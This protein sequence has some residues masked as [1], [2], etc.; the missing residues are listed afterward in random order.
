MSALNRSFLAGMLMLMSMPHA[1]AADATPL[2]SCG[3]DGTTKPKI[4][5]PHAMPPDAYPLISVVQGE[6]GN[7]LLEFTIR[8]DGSVSDPRVV[9]SS[10]FP[11]LDEAATENVKAWKYGPSE[12]EG[13]PV[14]CKWQANV[15]WKLYDAAPIFPENGPFGVITLGPEDYPSS[16]LR[17]KETGASAFIIMV[18]KDGKQMFD[19]VMVRS[20]GFADLDGASSDY[21]KN[22]LSV[23]PAELAGKPVASIVNIVIVWTPE[24]AEKKP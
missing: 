4:S 24:A 15:N 10:G 14:D 18:G 2:P 9:R 16:A 12:K 23:K 17:R 22:R 1:Y 5:G 20:S 11:R 7:V 21:V 3:E 13:K 6:Q 8:L 19:A